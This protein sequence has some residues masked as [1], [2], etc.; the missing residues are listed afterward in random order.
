MTRTEKASGID[1]EIGAKTR[2]AFESIFEAIDAGMISGNYSDAF[3]RVRE[4]IDPLREKI[5]GEICN[6][7]P[8]E[9]ECHQLMK[10]N[11][12]R[13]AA[14]G[15]FFRVD[16]VLALLITDAARSPEALRIFQAGY[17]FGAASGLGI[18]RL[19]GTDHAVVTATTEAT[20][21]LESRVR[22]GDG[23]ADLDKPRIE[24]RRN[25][26]ID[27]VRDNPNIKSVIEIAEAILPF[28]EKNLSLASLTAYIRREMRDHLPGHLRRK[29][30]RQ[31]PFG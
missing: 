31:I 20:E 18:F 9:F 11:S 30:S 10:S 8:G 28:E 25:R 24:N 12:E 16:N 13:K 21:Y 15:S 7:D 14:I 26:V 3:S 17:A 4:I 23:R 27:F 22:G 6:N 1:E 19:I 2:A 29:N 5:G